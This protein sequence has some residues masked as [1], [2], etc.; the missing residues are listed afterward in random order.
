MTCWSV[1]WYP[2]TVFISID[3]TIASRSNNYVLYKRSVPKVWLIVFRF[4]YLSQ[5]KVLVKYQLLFSIFFFFLQNSS[6]WQI[7]KC[8]DGYICTEEKHQ[9][10]GWLTLLRSGLAALL[11][12][13]Q[14][15]M[16]KRLLSSAMFHKRLMNKKYL[17]S[18]RLE[19]RWLIDC[20]AAWRVWNL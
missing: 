10:A 19:L 14:W 2:F 4:W 18:T 17:C 6:R 5:S 8:Y 7:Y 16:V 9:A 3:C 20:T 11:H 12:H 15:F 1:T 13:V